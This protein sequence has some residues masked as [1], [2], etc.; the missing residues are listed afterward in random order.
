MCRPL[1]KDPVKAV[2][3]ALVPKRAYAVEEAER[4]S[5]SSAISKKL[6]AIATARMIEEERE[7]QAAE[8]GILREV[9][10]VI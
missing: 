9:L 6:R 1:L 8:K 2:V 5:S 7:K 10:T 3:I 4:S